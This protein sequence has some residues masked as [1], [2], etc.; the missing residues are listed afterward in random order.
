MRTESEHPTPLGKQCS[1]AFII[2]L[3]SPLPVFNPIFVEAMCSINIGLLLIN[4]KGETHIHHIYLQPSKVDPHSLHC[5]CMRRFGTCNTLA[6]T[7]SVLAMHCSIEIKCISVTLVVPVSDA[8]TQRI[9][10]TN[11]DDDQR[12]VVHLAQRALTLP[13]QHSLSLLM[14]TTL[15]VALMQV[16]SLICL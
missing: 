10:T 16:T 5:L 6:R 14:S 3:Q 13:P 1:H 4:L 2:V 15:Q 11:W 12:L 9:A 8:P 7:D